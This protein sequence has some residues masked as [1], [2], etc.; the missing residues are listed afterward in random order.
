MTTR[1][2]R[3]LPTAS[4]FKGIPEALWTPQQRAAYR[5]ECA[6]WRR[7]FDAQSARRDKLKASALALGI[8]PGIV[9]LMSEADLVAA[10][11][12]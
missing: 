6:A 9:A 5:R 1:T 8:H 10:L 12:A 7:H 3:A 4:N 11:K 2:T